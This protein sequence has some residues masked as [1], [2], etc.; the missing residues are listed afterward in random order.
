MKRGLFLIVSLSD[1]LFVIQNRK[2]RSNGLLSVISS[3]FTD[4]SSMQK[5]KKLL[6]NILIFS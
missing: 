1:T 2:K 6:Y 4:F 5:R 3:H